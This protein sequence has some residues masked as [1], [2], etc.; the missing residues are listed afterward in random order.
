VRLPSS[1]TGFDVADCASLHRITSSLHH[2]IACIVTKTAEHLSNQKYFTSNRTYGILA[3]D[4]AWS[5]LG[6]AA[7]RVSTFDP[8]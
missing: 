5:T 6:T 4:G 3:K 1:S 8:L 2:I 7:F